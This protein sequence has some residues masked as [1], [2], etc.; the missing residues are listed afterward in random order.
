MWMF[1]P[2]AI[3]GG[4][5]LHQQ[6]SI[7]NFTNLV[8]SRKP[9]FGQNIKLSVFDHIILHWMQL[10]YIYKSY[11]QNNFFPTD[12]Y[13][14]GVVFTPTPKSPY[15][16][17]RGVFFHQHFNLNISLVFHK[18]GYFGSLKVNSDSSFVFRVV[19]YHKN[20]D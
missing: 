20:N 13:S 15:S 19:K 4:V 2:I 11:S 14:G 16:Y 9:K 8:D 1:N 6:N 12:Y 17:W 5:V 18:Y 10:L 3:L 7:L